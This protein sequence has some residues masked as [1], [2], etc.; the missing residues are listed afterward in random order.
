MLRTVF[1]R[2]YRISPNQVVP[3]TGEDIDAQ[4]ALVIGLFDRQGSRKWKLGFSDRG[5]LKYGF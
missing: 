1:V 5:V 3:Y 4:C 2:S